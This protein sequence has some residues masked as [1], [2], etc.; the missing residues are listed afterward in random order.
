M[1]YKQLSQTAKWRTDRIPAAKVNL[2]NYI[3]TENMLPYRSGVEYAASVPDTK[4]LSKYIAGDILLSNIRPYFKKI[5]FADTTG[6]CSNDVL[7][8]R[9]NGVDAKFLYYVLSDNNFFNYST[10]TSKG[11]KMPRGSKTAIMKYLV[12]DVD[13]P[14]QTRIAD[15]LSAYDDAIENNKRRI[16]LLEKAARELYR[17]WFVRMRFLGH[18]SVKIINGL[19][20]GWEVVPLGNM[21]NITSS[22][23]IYM[24]DYV[25][26]GI[27]FYRSKEVIQSANGEKLT[28]PLFISVVK[29][30][31]LKDRF[32]VPCENDILVTSVGTIGIS[33]LVDKRLFYFK[34]G[35]LT[36]LQSG[37]TPKIALYIYSW[38]N[39][40]MGKSTLLSSTIGTSQSA[41]T[42]EDL[43]RIKVIQPSDT[44]LLLF[45]EKT[46]PF[47]EQKRILHT[48]SQNLTRQ[49]DLLLPRLMSGKQEV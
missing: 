2:S 6:G 23:R 11:T 1:N 15:I 41:L 44:V 47:V 38:L 26:D 3:S 46:M 29:Y 8:V 16:A 45:Y 22:K 43:K 19:P 36:W 39:S 42:I 13:R 20:E 14:T 32:G 48:Q 21:A 34:D 25:E 7:V 28:E 18:E 5:W 27:P 33:F 37:A 10:V 30:N 24:S 35:N 49:R 9:P 40:D 4:T 31:E 17:E 12:P